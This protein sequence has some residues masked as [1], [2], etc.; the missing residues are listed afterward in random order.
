MLPPPST[1]IEA[2]EEIKMLP[3]NR[4]STV[5]PESTTRFGLAVQTRRMQVVPPIFVEANTS[6][7][8]VDE[9]QNVDPT[10]RALVHQ[11]WVPCPDAA[12]TL[13]SDRTGE[14]TAMLATNSPAIA[15]ATMRLFTLITFRSKSVI[16]FMN[17]E[18]QIHECELEIHAKSSR[19]DKGTSSP[20]D[21]SSRG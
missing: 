16:I 2:P 1:V 8:L 10:C 21:W 12:Y 3:I 11:V 4:M 18:G 7:V 14:A 5:V 6:Q 20:A 9:S 15:T 19:K 17:T 13:G